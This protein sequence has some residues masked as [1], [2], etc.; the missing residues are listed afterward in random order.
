MPLLVTLV[1]SVVTFLARALG[2]KLALVTI[3]FTSIVGMMLAVKIAIGAIISSVPFVGLPPAIFTVATS[4]LPDNT[5]DSLELII[6]ARIVIFV[7]ETQW[8]F[9]R[10][11]TTLL[12]SK[13]I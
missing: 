5:R 1:F 12:S 2:A 3:M 9:L 4:L 6:N 10:T 8:L 13:F 7:F 11:Y